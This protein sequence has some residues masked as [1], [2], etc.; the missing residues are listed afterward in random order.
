MNALNSAQG[1]IV[2]ALSVVAFGV[3]LMALVHALMQ[4]PDAFVA[5]G[6]RTKNFWL[7]LLGIAT[8]IGFV[9]LANS[10]VL[11]FLS[12]LAIV[13]AGVYLADVK[14]ALDQITGRY[15]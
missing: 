1:M 7:V 11:G 9:S 8:A 3:E 6:K 4:R 12:L 15:R 5:A 13:A 14:P 10:G 2:V